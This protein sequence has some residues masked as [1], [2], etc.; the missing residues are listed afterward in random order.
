MGE[1]ELVGVEEWS[2]QARNEASQPFFLKPLHHYY[3]YYYYYYEHQ[4]CM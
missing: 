3:H 2:T 1:E 4:I